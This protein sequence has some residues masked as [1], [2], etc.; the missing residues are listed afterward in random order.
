M[1][2]PLGHVVLI[3]DVGCFR[4]HFG[5]TLAV[6]VLMRVAWAMLR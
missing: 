6:T 5:G 3:G 2:V 4:G 1:G